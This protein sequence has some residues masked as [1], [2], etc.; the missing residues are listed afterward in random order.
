MPEHPENQVRAGDVLARDVLTAHGNVLLSAG[1]VLT[2]Q[3]VDLLR[4]F[5]VREVEVRRPDAPDTAGAGPVRQ[6]AVVV[7]TVPDASPAQAPLKDACARL[8]RVLAECLEAVRLGEKLPLNE[9]RAKL[10]DVIDQMAASPY[11]PLSFAPSEPKDPLLNRSIR[12]ALTARWLVQWTDVP[13]NEWLQVTLGALLSD[14]GF[15]KLDPSLSRKRP[16]LAPEEWDEWR[17]HP[18]YGFR[19]LI[20]LPS[21]HRGVALA[22]LQ[23]HERHDGSGYPL[24][25]PGANLHPYAKIAA[26]ADEFHALLEAESDGR[27]RPPLS[28]LEAL[29]NS[30]FGRLEPAF[31]R[32]FVEKM[33]ASQRGIMVRL[34]DGRIGEIVFADPRN[35][36]RP[37]VSVNGRI[38]NLDRQRE[39]DVVE[40][41]P[42]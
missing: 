32:V 30:S 21:L 5:L 34:S 9:L 6:A 42:I 12:M 15:A 31:V 7:K 22:A 3:D 17:K 35:P 10:S 14:I 16:P 41:F 4:H 40:I 18:V 27:R 26:I 11:H 29:Q 23:H 1:H 38:V 2:D 24:G 37:L 8:G 33:A 36:S 25:L 20:A 28:V 19:T 39:L 13:R